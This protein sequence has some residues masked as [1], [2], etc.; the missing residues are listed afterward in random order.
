MFLSDLLYETTTAILANKFRSGLTILGIVIGIGS[1]I[2][3]ISIGAGSRA[4]IESRIQ[5]MGSNLLYITPGT[6]RNFSPVSAGRGTASS[7]TIDDVIAI[8][9]QISNISGISPLIARRF[10]II[11]KTNNTNTQVQG[12]Y[13]EYQAIRNIQLESGS[14]FSNSELQSYAKVAVLGSLTRDDLFG[15]GVDVIG[16]TIKINGIIFKIIGITQSKGGTAM[17]DDVIYI[18]FTTAQRFLMGNNKYVSAI[19]VQTESDKLIEEVKTT[20]TNFLMERHNIFNVNSLD[21]TITT[22]ADILQT[23]SSITDTLTIL[24]AS[25]AGISLLVG[26]IGIMNMMMTMVNERIKEIGLRKAIGAKKTE[27]TQQFLMESVVLSFIGG[28]FGIGLGTILAYGISYFT[29]ITTQ[30]SW[31]AVLLACSVSML[32]GVIF[33]YWPSRKA[34]NL[35]PIEALRYE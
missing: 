11:S 32:I 30:I 20:I 5:S 27:I 15:E 6:Q 14:F 17:D 7:L 31:F 28:I 23:A 8:Q 10:Q 34:A 26:G 24:L 18:P 13:P 21:F 4:S 9:K 16:N 12:V 1:V 3:M 33:G 22:Q 29:S 35:N 2:A 25:I 19:Y